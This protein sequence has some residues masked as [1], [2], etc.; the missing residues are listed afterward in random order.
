VFSVTRQ[1]SFQP[2][3]SEAVPEV[4][5]GEGRACRFETPVFSD[6]LGIR[7]WLPRGGPS[8]CDDLRKLWTKFLIDKLLIFLLQRP[9]GMQLHL[10]T[11][12]DVFDLRKRTAIHP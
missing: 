12:G 9:S 3:F 8:L 11:R 4:L 2:T 5:G 1:N 10:L 7:P 6:V